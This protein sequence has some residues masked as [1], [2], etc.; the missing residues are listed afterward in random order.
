MVPEAGNLF[1][2]GSLGA[3]T[4]NINLNLSKR[5]SHVCDDEH[6]DCKKKYQVV[7]RPISLGE[8][9]FVFKSIWH[10][11]L[12][13]C[14]DKKQEHYHPDQEREI[15]EVH[16]ND[17]FHVI[18]LAGKLLNK[19]EPSEE[20][21]TPYDEF[22]KYAKTVIV[23]ESEESEHL[24]LQYVDVKYMPQ[25]IFA[26]FVSQPDAKRVDAAE[27]L[28]KYDSQSE[29]KQIISHLVDQIWTQYDVNGDGVLDPQESG[30]FIR[31]VL[32]IHER[33]CAAS[34]DRDLHAIDQADIDRA[35]QE[36]DKAEDGKI[37]K[38]EMNDWLVKY[39]KD[40]KHYKEEGNLMLQK[41]TSI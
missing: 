13:G 12:Q 24:D 30:N 5:A 35:I 17:L 41:I 10:A 34:M 32:T 27:L 11:T 18:D 20:D 36:C 37:T 39:M 19:G 40:H 31:M 33:T 28:A 6:D 14:N 3:A 9:Q 38:V 16:L 7:G 2:P 1:S 8:C 15:N 22:M 4:K 25:I 21:C 23:A 29:S 26:T